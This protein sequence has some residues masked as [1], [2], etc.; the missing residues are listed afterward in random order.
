MRPLV[1]FALLDLGR[2][3]CHRSSIRFQCVNALVAGEAEVSHLEVEL[4]V[5]QDVF[6]FY[7]TVDHA[8]GMHVIKGV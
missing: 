1:S 3:I 8:F 6:Q 5:D 7:V 2:H 4:L